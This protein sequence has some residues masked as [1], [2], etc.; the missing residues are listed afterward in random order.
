MKVVFLEDVPD[1]AGSG[2]VK[3]VA[4]GYARNFLIPRKLAAQ[5]T[6]QVTSQLEAQQASR[7]KKKAHMAAEIDKMAQQLDGSQI[8]IKVKG[9]VKGRLYGSVTSAD[10]AQAL[11]QASGLE[12]D[13]R[14]VELAEPIRE[15]GTFEVAV[16]LGKDALPRIKV[17]VVEQESG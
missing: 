6:N 17:N 13:K 2:E 7:A 15:L 8:S 1:V 9:G 14:K 16:K 12:I 4:D 5:A 3:E 11:S 10:I